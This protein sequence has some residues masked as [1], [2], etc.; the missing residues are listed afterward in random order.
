MN[1]AQSELARHWLTTSPTNILCVSSDAVVKWL[2]QF[3]MCKGIA[4]K[5]EEHKYA[6]LCSL[7]QKSPLKYRKKK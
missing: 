7:S 3:R 1:G 6:Y 2:G 5:W 4:G